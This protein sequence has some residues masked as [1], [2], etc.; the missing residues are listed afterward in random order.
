MTQT[1]PLF[2]YCVNEE[3][4]DQLYDHNGEKTF[5][6]LSV[7]KGMHIK[8]HLRN[9]WAAI[10]KKL[11]Y[12][13]GKCDYICENMRCLTDHEIA[14]QSENNFSYTECDYKSFSKTTLSKHITEHNHGNRLWVWVSFFKFLDK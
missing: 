11:T 5:F 7:I 10:E 14:H 6:V 3:L 4:K 1:I 2:V 8:L 9:T 13:C 12:N